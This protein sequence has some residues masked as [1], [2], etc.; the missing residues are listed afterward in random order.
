MIDRSNPWELLQQDVKFSC[1]YFDVRQDLVSHAGGPPRP[2]NSIR[3]KY[4]GVCI[5][6]VDSQGLVTLVGQYRYVLGRYTWELPGGGAPVGAD[7]LEVAQQELREET[8]Y[9]AKQ[10][11]RIIEGD[12]APGT[13]DERTPGYIAW[14]LEQGEAQ[15]DAEESL[16]LRKVPFSEA[17]KLALRGGVNHLIGVALLLAVQVRANQGTLPHDFH[18]LLR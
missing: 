18:K 1:R 9:R 2:Y 8:G 12:V 17:V 6:P 3:V 11:H 13:L 10:W 16:S 15:P 4:S 14:E 5:L 7:P